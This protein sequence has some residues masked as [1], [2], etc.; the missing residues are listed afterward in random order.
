MPS[1]PVYATLDF[2]VH[3]VNSVDQGA[4]RSRRCASRRY[5][6]RQL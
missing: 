6:V 1:F 4:A 5:L 2:E 3:S